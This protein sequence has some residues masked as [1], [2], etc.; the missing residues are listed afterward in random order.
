MTTPRMTRKAR[1]IIDSMVESNSITADGKNWLIQATDPFHDTEIPAVGYPDVNSCSTIAQCFTFTVNVISPTPALSATWDAHIFFNPTSFDFSTGTDVTGQTVPCN[2]SSQGSFTAFPVLPGVVKL[3][4]GWNVITVPSGADWISGNVLNNGSTNYTTIAYPKAAAGGDFRL[5]AGGAEVV[6][7]TPELYKGGAI[8]CYRSPSIPT[9]TP[10]INAQ[11]IPLP[12]VGVVQ[13]KFMLPFVG[14]PPSTQAAAQLYPNS[15]TWAAEEGCYSI[16]TL[17]DVDNKLMKTLP[18]HVVAMRPSS[19]SQVG[20]NGICW[21]SNTLGNLPGIDLSSGSHMRA[22]PW[23]NNGMI[24][25][26]LQQQATLQLTTKYFVE[27]IP[28]IA[29]PE[30]LVL[31]RPPAPFDPMAIEI[32]TRCMGQLPVGVMVKENPLGEWFND[33]LEAVQDY[34]PKIG[35]MFGPAGGFLGNAAAKAAGMALNS[36]A[37]NPP[38]QRNPLHGRQVGKRQ[39]PKQMNRTPKQSQPQVMGNAKKKRN[40]RRK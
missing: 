20:S 3:Q 25:T 37:R 36:R 40:R 10:V 19:A 39:G 6:N 1:T 29:Q 28:T 11:A 9:L 21:C 8:T 16:C 23:D 27:R 14:L 35:A 15:R 34:A 5:V 2:I 22:L 18:N 38:A 33:V 26:G 12:G 32:Y 24:F 17:S 7:T 13:E 4:P 30:L 31:A